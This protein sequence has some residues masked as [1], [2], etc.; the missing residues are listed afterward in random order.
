MSNATFEIGF[1]IKQ[2]QNLEIVSLAFS[3]N[4]R[5][6]IFSILFFIYFISKLKLLKDVLIKSAYIVVVYI[7]VFIF[8]V[9][10]GRWLYIIFS[11]LIIF[12]QSLK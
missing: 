3:Q 11:T 8:A 2:L 4:N 1:N 5:S 6:Y 10:W 7:P 12:T 9:D